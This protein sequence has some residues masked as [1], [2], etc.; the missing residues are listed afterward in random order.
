MNWL[1]A[2]YTC[3]FKILWS[4]CN[5]GWPFHRTK[6]SPPPTPIHWKSIEINIVWYYMNCEETY[7]HQYDQIAQAKHTM[8][9]HT[10]GLYN[11]LSVCYTNYANKSFFLE[12]CFHTAGKTGNSDFFLQESVQMGLNFDIKIF[13][14]SLTWCSLLQW[15]DFKLYLHRTLDLHLTNKINLHCTWLFSLFLRISKCELIFTM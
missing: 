13:E 10:V 15:W 5:N 4:R 7:Y 11:I 14:N 12:L 2:Q 9:T 1:A 3:F 8:T 6:P